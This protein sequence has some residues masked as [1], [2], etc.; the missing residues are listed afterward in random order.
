MSSK[1]R[2][3]IYGGTFSP[4]HLG[5]VGA[6]KSFYD[7]VPLDKLLIIPDFLPPH[8]QIDGE[9]TADDRIEMCRLA[10]SDVSGAE[11]SDI[12]IKR[13]GKSYTALTLAE[14][15][16][17]GNELY[18]LCGTDMFLTL[19]EWYMP[20][21]IFRLATICFVRRENDKENDL[22]IK[23]LTEEYINRFSARIIPISAP[24][25]EISSSELRL[26][27]KNDGDRLVELLPNRVLEYIRHRGLYK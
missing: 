1:T 2:I 10:F 17:E 14:L 18:F 3:G 15:S 21:E 22:V 13:G 26:A 12:E 25:T 4:P 5:H 11:V 9:I 16:S 19:G 27:I 24:V 8:K 7:A 23:R 20:E 6:A